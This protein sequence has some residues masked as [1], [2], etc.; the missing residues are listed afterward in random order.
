[1]KSP[2]RICR[3]FRVQGKHWISDHPDSKLLTEYGIGHYEKCIPSDNLEYLE[4]RYD[5]C[6]VQKSIEE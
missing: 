3:A 1:M 2:C 6:M 4:W 5:E